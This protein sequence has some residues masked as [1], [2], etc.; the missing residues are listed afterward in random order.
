[1]TKRD[2]VREFLI[3][4]LE[5]K[6]DHG[7]VGD[8]DSL[9]TSGRLDSVDIIDTLGFLERTYGFEMDPAE[10]D[11]IHFDSVENIVNLVEKQQQ[12]RP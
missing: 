7:P 2:Q 1:M 3:S 5:S 10:F 11:Q 8:A 6:D 9:V 12:S 4:L